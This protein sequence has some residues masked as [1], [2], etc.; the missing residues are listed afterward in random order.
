MQ[1]SI[2]LHNLR[3]QLVDSGLKAT[4]QRIVVLE[5]VTALHGLHPMA[6]EVYQRLK[7]A[8]PSISLGTVYKTL[9]TFA[10][11][12]LVRR[13]LSQ[14]GGKRY[15]A[16]TDAHSHIYCSNTKE[17]VDFEDAELDELLTA[18]FKKRNIENFDL[19]GFS[20]QLTG[21]KVEPDK[22]IRISKA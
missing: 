19:K 16:N 17:I 10:D 14:D 22:Q 12:G 5:A 2:T 9:D 18:F 20:V 15:D 4:H 7:P 13:V 6:E 8:N 21:T 3:Q 11:T 1:Q